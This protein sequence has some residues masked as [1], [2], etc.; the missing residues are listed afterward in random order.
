MTSQQEILR[1]E[2]VVPDR[3]IGLAPH[4]WK[5]WAGERKGKRVHR[6]DC[7]RMEWT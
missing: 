2:G 4:F 3:S 1:S 6:E 5:I 7:F